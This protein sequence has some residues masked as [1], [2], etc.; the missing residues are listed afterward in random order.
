MGKKNK[1]RNK[2][3]TQVSAAVKKT[4]VKRSPEQ[5][6]F[7]LLNIVDHFPHDK[8]LDET[9]IAQFTQLLAQIPAELQ[10]KLMKL[11]ANNNDAEA[12]AAILRANRFNDV[13]LSLLTLSKCREYLMPR[14]AGKDAVL[15]ALKCRRAIV[16]K[17]DLLNAD[18]LFKMLAMSRFHIHDFCDAAILHNLLALFYQFNAHSEIKHLATDFFMHACNTPHTEMMHYCIHAGLLPITSAIA[19]TAKVHSP[20][21]QLYFYGELSAELAVENLAKQFVGLTIKQVSSSCLLEILA[22]AFA[23]RQQAVVA[24]INSELNSRGDI[25]T[26]TELLLNKSLVENLIVQSSVLQS[27][28]TPQTIA[29]L[30]VNHSEYEGIHLI[31]NQ[32]NDTVINELQTQLLKIMQDYI[33]HYRF[34]IHFLKQ[35]FSDLLS[36]MAK[37]CELTTEFISFIMAL[38]IYAEDDASLRLLCTH[39]AQASAQLETKFSDKIAKF[40]NFSGEDQPLQTALKIGSKRCAVFLYSYLMDKNSALIAKLNDYN[41]ELVEAFLGDPDRNLKIIRHVMSSADVSLMR[42]AEIEKC[43]K[44]Y[45]QTNNV[46]RLVLRKIVKGMVHFLIMPVFA[47]QRDSIQYEVD[48]FEDLCLA[49]EAVAQTEKEYQSVLACTRQQLTW[50]YWLQDPL[51]ELNE[52]QKKAIVESNLFEITQSMESEADK[53]EK[54]LRTLFYMYR[55]NK[56][57]LKKQLEQQHSIQRSVTSEEGNESVEEVSANIVSLLCCFQKYDLVRLLLVL[58][59]DLNYGEERKIENNLRPLSILCSFGEEDLATTFIRFVGQKQHALRIDWCEKHSSPMYLAMS[60]CID[61]YPDESL[62]GLLELESSTIQKQSDLVN[63]QLLAYTLSLLSKLGPKFIAEKSRLARKIAEFTLA[64]KEPLLDVALGAQDGNLVYVA[65]CHAHGNKVPAEKRTDCI[66][67]ACFSPALLLWET[68]CP[69]AAELQKKVCYADKGYIQAQSRLNILFA[70][71]EKS[72]LSGNLNLTKR[73]LE[74]LAAFADLLLFSGRQYNYFFALICS[75]KQC[76]SGKFGIAAREF[77]Q[78]LF[79]LLMAEKTPHTLVNILDKIEYVTLCQDAFKLTKTD[80]HQ[81]KIVKF[82]RALVHQEQ[83]LHEEKYSKSSLEY[84]LYEINI[85]MLNVTQLH[86]Y[87]QVLREK[88]RDDQIEVNIKRLLKVKN[89]IVLAFQV[90]KAQFNISQLQLCDVV[91]ILDYEKYIGKPSLFLNNYIIKLLHEKKGIALAN[92]DYAVVL[93]IFIQLRKIDYVESILNAQ[94]CRSLATETMVTILIEMCKNRFPINII[95]QF[96]HTLGEKKLPVSKL[97]IVTSTGHSPL[98]VL[99]R[100][101]HYQPAVRKAMST[102][103]IGNPALICVDSWIQFYLTS[104]WLILQSNKNISVEEKKKYQELRDFLNERISLIVYIRQQQDIELLKQLISYPPAFVA[105]LQ[106]Y[107]VSWVLSFAIEHQQS[108]II[109]A[110][111]SAM[112]DK[113]FSFPAAMIMHNQPLLIYLCDRIKQHEIDVEL[114]QQLL[115]NICAYEIELAPEQ[116]AQYIDL[117]IELLNRK[118]NIDLD[119]MLR[120]P[121]INNDDLMPVLNFSDNKKRDDIAVS[122]LNHFALHSEKLALQHLT[123]SRLQSVTTQLDKVNLCLKLV[124]EV[125]LEDIVISDFCQF[126]SSLG[127]KVRAKLLQEYRLDAQRKSLVKAIDLFKKKQPEGDFNEYARKQLADLQLNLDQEIERIESTIPEEIIP[128][129]KNCEAFLADSKNEIMWIE[130]KQVELNKHSLHSY[131]AVT[132]GLF[133]EKLESLHQLLQAAHDDHQKQLKTLQIQQEKMKLEQEAQKRREEK[134]QDA[135]KQ[136]L[137][138]KAEKRAAK[139]Q[140]SQREVEKLAAEEQCSQREVEKRAAEEQRSQRKAEKR[141]AEKQRLQRDVEEQ[142]AETKHLQMLAAP[143]FVPSFAANAQ[144]SRSQAGYQAK[145]F[146]IPNAIEQYRNFL[147]KKLKPLGITR[148]CMPYINLKFNRALNLYEIVNTQSE[149]S[150]VAES[151]TPLYLSLHSLIGLHLQQNLAIAFD[152]NRYPGDI[153]GGFNLISATFVRPIQVL[154]LLPNDKAILYQNRVA[155]VS[156]ATGQFQA[157]PQLNRSARF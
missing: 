85:S 99:S 122:I 92:K 11:A 120:L 24:A 135:E 16:R 8:A 119:S 141:A 34:N 143:E 22:L 10:T 62:K 83:K 69:T 23:L 118:Q 65:L 136:R 109:N 123:N 47:F 32:L 149:E 71:T 108:E 89:F 94:Q 14:E 98:A 151:Q 137:K 88:L 52:E 96:V 128:T 134:E 112:K 107:E 130:S 106:Q 36:A 12:L 45:A 157:N 156:F 132:F 115:Q 60:Q 49:L 154:S 155:K 76:F 114:V 145:F 4:I 67:V 104:C 80:S 148:A 121:G 75:A 150:I 42:G 7:H 84:L 50:L 82:N 144:P 5:E 28:L 57:D 55:H 127:K 139:E 38:F 64:I 72:I 19:L 153:I 20:L 59:P 31:G 56:V 3:S 102:A 152:K 91:A 103:N 117:L 66:D 48:Q 41:A 44:H 26:A 147:T 6:F 58:M 77:Q 68:L 87:V 113:N 2:K 129:L 124:I 29:K 93:K 105:A 97:P 116:K 110:L 131:D 126:Y 90:A 61:V 13:S 125:R 35:R 1:N 25:A 33:S 9:R 15:A 63:L 78:Y 70:E 39:Q 30:I 81:E 95:L 43:L 17:C 86:A 51:R 133:T 53:E 37:Q 73:H 79:A 46:D 146:A 21:S 54:F 101:E 18:D 27:A 142:A 74:N 100:V 138:Y 111:F 140:R 40:F